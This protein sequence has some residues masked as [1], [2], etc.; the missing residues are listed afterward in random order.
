M[1]II[2]SQLAK[3]R[4]MRAARIMEGGKELEYRTRKLLTEAK[5]DLDKA[6][7]GLKIADTKLTKANKDVTVTEDNHNAGLTVVTYVDEHGIGD[8]FSIRQLS[9]E[10]SLGEAN[11]GKF[12]AEVYV[13][14]FG[15]KNIIL[16]ISIDLN[17]IADLAKAVYEEIV[18]RIKTIG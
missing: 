2:A 17:K 10:A 13:R 12:K 1:C 7:K 14:Y 11:L 5:Q 8:I 15:N 6:D 9:F 3:W 4:S 18:K 16:R